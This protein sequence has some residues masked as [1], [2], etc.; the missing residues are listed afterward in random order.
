MAY[1][2]V[3]LYGWRDF[4]RLPEDFDLSSIGIRTPRSEVFRFRARFRAAAAYQRLDLY[5]YSEATARGYTAFCRVFFVYSAFESFMGILER[6][7]PSEMNDV[8]R[9]HGADA[10]LE[11]LWRRDRDH[12]LYDFLYQRVSSNIKSELE[13]FARLAPCNIAVL[14]AAIRHVFAHGH[15]TPH[16]GNGSPKRAAE[17]CDAISDFL[18][19]AMSAEF[20]RMVKGVGYQ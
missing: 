3:P 18:L 2:I 17:I 5:G 19:A 16:A 11:W 14:A 9:R 10:L 15:L 6:K 8:L 4:C 1:A 12:A 7:Y 20:G 13:G